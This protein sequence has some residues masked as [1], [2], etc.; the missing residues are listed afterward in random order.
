MEIHHDCVNGIQIEGRYTFDGDK[1]VLKEWR[2]DAGCG[3]GFSEWYR[4]HGNRKRDYG[5]LKLTIA[6]K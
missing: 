5:V 2:I 1:W 4:V 6:A 3:Y